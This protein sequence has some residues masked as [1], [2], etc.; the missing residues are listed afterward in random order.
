MVRFDYQFL[1][2]LGEKEDVEIVLGVHL[3]QEKFSFSPFRMKVL[4]SLYYMSLFTYN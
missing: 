3:F 2:H 4:P 1:D